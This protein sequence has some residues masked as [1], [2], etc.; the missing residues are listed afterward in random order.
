M[1]TSK[2]QNMPEMIEKMKKEFESFLQQSW[3]QGE[4]AMNTIWSRMPA[5]DELVYDM[6]ETTDH[7]IVFVE[8]PGVAVSDLD[9]SLT[10]N[11]LSI[12]GKYLELQLAPMDKLIRKYRPEGEFEQA[13]TLPLAVDLQNIQASAKDGVLKIELARKESEKTHPISVSVTH[14]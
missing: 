5:N 8:I 6:I 3:G 9:L 4:K 14:S 7:I 12:K 11:V 10:G 2:K 13:I 1:T